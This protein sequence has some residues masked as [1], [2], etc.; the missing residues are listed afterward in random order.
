MYLTGSQISVFGAVFRKL[1]SSS[2][3]SGRYGGRAAGGAS[4]AAATAAVR[5][6]RESAGSRIGARDQQ[7]TL[8]TPPRT[9]TRTSRGL[10]RRGRRRH[11]SSSSRVDRRRSRSKSAVSRA[12]RPASEDCD[13]QLVVELERSIVEVGGPDDA[14]DAVDDHRLRVHHRRPVLVRYDAAS[15]AGARRRAAGELHGLCVGDIA[16]DQDPDAH[17]A[18]P[19][20][21]ERPHRRFVREKYG[22]R[23]S[24]VRLAPAIERRNSSFI[25]AAAAGRRAPE[26]ERPLVPVGGRLG[27][28]L[29]PGVTGRRVSIKFS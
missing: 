11:S 15:Q 16:F 5:S 19:R 28:R 2:E 1:Q 10:S 17:A 12:A 8:R 9:S 4:W 29:E 26:H 27:R 14:P 24:S 20:P 25:V 13:V 3:G 18:P 6:V 23:M 7:I 22:E 21:L